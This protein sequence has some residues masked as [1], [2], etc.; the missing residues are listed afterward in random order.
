M[1]SKFGVVKTLLSGNSLWLNWKSETNHFSA[2]RIVQK[3][4]EGDPNMSLKVTLSTAIEVHQIQV[5]KT[6][7]SP[8]QE[9]FGQQGLVSGFDGYNPNSMEP[10]V[11]PM[12]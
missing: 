8:K 11:V 5:N 1:A 10:A 6:G 12:Q 2:Y 3:L 4:S 7:I 9:T